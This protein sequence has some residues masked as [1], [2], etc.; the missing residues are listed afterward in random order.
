MFTAS[1]WIWYWHFAEC[2]ED[3]IIIEALTYKPVALR[4]GGFVS[5]GEWESFAGNLWLKMRQNRREP[6]S[7]IFSSHLCCVMEAFC[8]DNM[9][10]LL[11]A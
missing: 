8:D 2:G 4:C 5:R 9:P 3:I 10:V 11:V 6:T 7:G 1:L